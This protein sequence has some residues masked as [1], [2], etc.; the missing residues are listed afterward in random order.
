MPPGQGG[1]PGAAAP[2][3]ASVCPSA[4]LYAFIHLVI[5][6][7]YLFQRYRAPAGLQDAFV[8]HSHISTH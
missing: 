6:I 7:D 5:F 8:K 1:L 3:R 4:Q 2:A